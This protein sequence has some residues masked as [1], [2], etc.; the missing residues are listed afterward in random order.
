MKKLISLMMLVALMALALAACEGATTTR[1][2]TA[3][4]A[5]A[6]NTG[7]PPRSQRGR[8][9]GLRAVSAPSCRPC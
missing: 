8:S 5:P 9:F 4:E 3:T 1:T 2:T 7:T 6:Q